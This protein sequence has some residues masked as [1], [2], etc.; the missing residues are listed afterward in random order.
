MKN[1][2]AVI[3][4]FFANSVSGLA[5]G[6]SMIA[7]PWFFNSTLQN[8]SL[9][10]ISYGTITFLTIFWSSYSGTLIDKYSRKKIFLSLNLAGFAVLGS[11]TLVSWF[12]G[13]LPVPLV[14]LVFASTFFIFNVHYPNL[15][16]L[17]QEITH[18][19]YYSK[20]NSYLEIQGQLTTAAAGGMAALLLSGIPDGRIIIGNLDV[21]VPFT[22][23]AVSLQT[24]FAINAGTYLAAFLILTFLSYRPVLQRNV[25]SGNV[26]KRV[27]S[28]FTL[29]AGQPRLFAFGILSHNIFVIVLVKLFFLFAMYVHNHLQ[30]PAYI[31]AFSDMLFALGALFAGI[32]A[33]R[34]Y[35]NFNT[36]QAIMINLTL[37]T[38]IMFVFSF[39][40]YIPLIF[41]VS[42]LLGLA[43]SATRI[44]RVTYIFNHVSNSIIGRA[45]SVFT[46][47]NT[48]LR[49]IFI[50]LFS[51]AFFAQNNNVVYAYMIFGVFALISLVIL[52]RIYPSLPKN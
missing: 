27:R 24:I 23:E 51:L 33:R 30:Q 7:I 26:W 20:V 49:M 31:Y 36:V 34:L 17:I 52:A 11:V 1:R 16:A 46:V 50:G 28:G 39:S 44:L 47:I 9:L 45:N 3:L 4:L 13:F 18:Q 19:R 32:F 37:A 15:Y 14:I 8:P 12:V 43:N 41:M 25:E 35:R 5:Q 10:G 48:T 6:I 22:L 21:A 2:H 40:A 29:L 42:F 38:V